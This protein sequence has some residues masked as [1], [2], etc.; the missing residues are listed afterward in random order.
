MKE[1]NAVVD[2]WPL[3]LSLVLEKCRFGSINLLSVPLEIQISLIS[4]YIPKFMLIY[5]FL[6]HA[7]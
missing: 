2:W 6:R 4:K 7:T 3:N 5:Q 1:Q